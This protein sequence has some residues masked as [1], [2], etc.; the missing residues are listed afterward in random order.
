[1]P[2]DDDRSSKRLLALVPAAILVVA[3]IASFVL[4]RYVFV[5]QATDQDWQRASEYV[6]ENLGDDDAIR[7]YPAWT[8]TP[9]PYLVD[10]RMRF[11]RQYEPVF[12]DVED[13]ERIWIMTEPGE[14][15]AALDSLPF[16]A[17]PTDASKRFDTV[18]VLAVKRPD[19]PTYRHE[20]LTHLDEAEV[21][22][23][24]GEDIIECKNWS[25]SDRRWDCGPRQDPWIFVGETIRQLDDD[26]RH[27]IWAHPPP[28]NYAVQTR[29]PDVKMGDTFRVRAGPTDH[30]WRSDRGPAIRIDVEIGDKSATHFFEPRTQAWKAV[31]VDT[32][33][34]KGQKQ[35]VVVR[36]HAT[37][38]WERFFCFNGWAVDGSP[39]GE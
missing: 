14:R 22:R 25:A 5:P 34:M 37:P 15:D 39:I 30:A 26:P 12:G 28:N 16:S 17:E 21:T 6:L 2:S 33:S 4:Q 8:E 9:Y 29:F 19:T 31:D 36:V 38:I 1:M 27:C 24:R 32:S 35:D 11:V 23:I 3:G 20:L 18:D 13:F 10:A 7:V